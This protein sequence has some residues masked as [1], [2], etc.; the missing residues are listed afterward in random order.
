MHSYIDPKYAD[1]RMK[2]LGEE[3]AEVIQAL[4]KVQRFGLA[5]RHYYD[6][7]ISN[8]DHLVAELGDLQGCIDNMVEMGLVTQEALDLAAA[9]KRAKMVRWTY[10]LMDGSLNK[11]NH[12][13]IG[14]WSTRKI[15]G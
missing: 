12:A 10:W 13:E 11:G 6:P 14:D 15:D 3:C 9:A 5:S 8:E 1:E 7:T 4:F 2:I